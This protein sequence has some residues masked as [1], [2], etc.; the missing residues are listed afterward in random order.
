MTDET[1]AIEPVDLPT[2]EP[3]DSGQEPATEV[4]TS[5][6][7]IA[8]LNAQNAELLSANEA[9]T[10]QVAALSATNA[11]LSAVNSELLLAVAGDGEGDAVS[12]LTESEKRDVERI[13][14]PDI[15]DLF[16]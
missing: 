10:S 13:D 2:D 15:D 9:L 5:A 6:E 7:T 1:E 14:S 3:A 11:E 12:E 8:S 4:D 16:D